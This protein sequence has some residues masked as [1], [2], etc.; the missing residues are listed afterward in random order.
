[1]A[2]CRICG[3]INRDLPPDWTN[4]LCPICEIDEYKTTNGIEVSCFDED[5]LETVCF[6]IAEQIGIPDVLLDAAVQEGC[7]AY[8]EGRDIPAAIQFWAESEGHI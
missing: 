4:W 1:M 2:T 8:R 6:E 7:I 3:A 5:D